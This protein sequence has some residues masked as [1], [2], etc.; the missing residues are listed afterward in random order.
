VFN[1][2]GQ[3]L[4]GLR[5]LDLYAG[6]GLYGLE[7]LARG[8]SAATFVEQDP[9][10]MERLRRNLVRL[11]ELEAEVHTL[12][13]PVERAVQRL[14]AAGEAF[15][16]VFADPPYQ[17]GD[18]QRLARD[19]AIAD[20][21]RAGG[22]FLIEHPGGQAIDADPHFWRSERQRRYG[23]ASVTLLERGHP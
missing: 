3:N 10:T 12:R 22:T 21:V 20:L 1:I 19:R 13:S 2:I 16:L 7:A 14:R 23:S 5:V 6:I 11:G 4:E 15:D 18:G 8:A 17:S 9:R